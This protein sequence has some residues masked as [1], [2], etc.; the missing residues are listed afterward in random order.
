MRSLF[1]QRPLTGAEIVGIIVGGF[2]LLPLLLAGLVALT[3]TLAS[4]PAVLGLAMGGVG[5]LIAQRLLAREAAAA[6]RRVAE[7]EHE[8]AVLAEQVRRLEATVDEFIARDDER[9][10][11]ER[12]RRSG[13]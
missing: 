3:T 13:R 5:A 11:S 8:N 1:P 4:W 6:R 12:L 10:W 7:L 2:F 9:D